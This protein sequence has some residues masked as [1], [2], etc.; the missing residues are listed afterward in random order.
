[1]CGADLLG[2]ARGTGGRQRD[3]GEDLAGQ[4]VEGVG[5][6]DLGEHRLKDLSRPL[7]LYQIVADGLTADFPPLRTLEYPADDLL[8]RVGDRRRRFSAARRR[9]RVLARLVRRA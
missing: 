7:R 9:W 3:D 4:A 1:M 6:D 5:L 8:G 2:G